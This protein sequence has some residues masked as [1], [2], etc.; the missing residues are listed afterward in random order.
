MNAMASTRPARKKAIVLLSG[1]LDSAVALWWAKDQGY[2]P[3]ALTLSYHSRANRE[4]DAARSVAR[5]AGGYRHLEIDVGFLREAGDLGPT[6]SGKRDKTQHG[7]QGQGGVTNGEPTYI[8]ARN[9][10]FYGIASYYAEVLG[11]QAIIGGHTKGDGALFPDAGAKFFDALNVA[12]SLG[13]EVGKE[14]KL[15]IMQP[16]ISLD[17][18]G[19]VRLGESLGAPMGATWSCH[20]TG[21]RP[22]GECRGCTTRA[23]GF[24][25]SGLVD[26]PLEP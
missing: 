14:G 3:I 2:D 22:C 19:V 6:V 11:A 12:L 26:R 10:I 5:R 21:E 9:V 13:T 20:G 24:Q 17:K 7:A 16:L 4:R 23:R 15:E 1:G 18:A 25:E 8:P